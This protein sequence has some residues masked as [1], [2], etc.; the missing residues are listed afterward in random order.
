MTEE[1]AIN[2][3]IEKKLTG[4]KKILLYQHKKF[5]K[6]NDYDGLAGMM[7]KEAGMMIVC[8]IIYGIVLIGMAAYRFVLYSRDGSGDD[9]FAAIVDMLLVGVALF[10]LRRSKRIK[11]T[12]SSVRDELKEKSVQE[13]GDVE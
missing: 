12:C 13:P 2:E 4:K 10:F 1:K 6:D 5:L 8:C 7:M 9:L 11:E 3:E